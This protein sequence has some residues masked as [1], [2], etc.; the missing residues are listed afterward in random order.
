MVPPL[1]KDDQSIKEYVEWRDETI[2]HV[3]ALIHNISQDVNM[4]LLHLIP[5]KLVELD[6]FYDNFVIEVNKDT[7]KYTRK[8]ILNQLSCILMKSST[9]HVQSFSYMSFN[10]RLLSFFTV[11]YKDI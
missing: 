7:I 11:V 8:S 2:A 5:L 6:N 4:S 9:Q 10:Y 3:N 1:L